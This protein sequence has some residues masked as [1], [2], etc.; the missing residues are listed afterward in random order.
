MGKK[1]V[2]RLAV[3]IGVIAL[4]GGGGY[5]R[6]RF[7]VERMARDVINQA[8]RAEQ[9]ADYAKAQELYR[10]HLNVVQDDAEVKLK[11][12]E[13]LLKGDGA[14]RRREDALQIFE[15]VLGQYPGR[16]KVRRRAAELA[17]EL[18]FTG[19]GGGFEQGRGDGEG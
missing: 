8:E 2:K 11:L 14:T 9:Q 15:G 19:G 13:A 5:V 6:W 17:A 18:A 12:A 10:E 4:V 1:T 7:Q 16:D 3:L